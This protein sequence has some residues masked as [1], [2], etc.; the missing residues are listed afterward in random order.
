VQPCVELG[1]TSRISAR[2]EQA[3]TEGPLG[4]RAGRVDTATTADHDRR[5]T[6]TVEYSP[7][8]RTAQGDDRGLRLPAGVGDNGGV[9]DARRQA[10][11]ART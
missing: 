9:S 3:G 11:A 2:W 6:T 1:A 4:R 7:A 8:A 5:V 10:G